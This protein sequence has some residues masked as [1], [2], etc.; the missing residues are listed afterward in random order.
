L[1]RALPPSQAAREGYKGQLR[2][3]LSYADGLAIFACFA[4]LRETCLSPAKS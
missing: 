1:P 2:K 3:S 4:A